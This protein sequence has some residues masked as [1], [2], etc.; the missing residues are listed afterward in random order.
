MATG[1]RATMNAIVTAIA[2]AAATKT[3]FSFNR[4]SLFLLL[5]RDTAQL[6]ERSK[7]A[8]YPN[9]KLYLVEILQVYQLVR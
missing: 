8:F 9:R 7:I 4:L 2:T 3:R 5:L 6:S 1:R